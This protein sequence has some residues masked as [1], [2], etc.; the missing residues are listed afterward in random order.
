MRLE[1]TQSA[2]KNDYIWRSWAI[3]R[4]RVIQPSELYI[5][6]GRFLII[7]AVRMR[8]DILSENSPF[9]RT[10]VVSWRLLHLVPLNPRY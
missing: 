4:R 7:T 1:D 3:L 6:M 8:A 9:A 10:L 5:V 2:R